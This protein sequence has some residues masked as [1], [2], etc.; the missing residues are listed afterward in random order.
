MKIRPLTPAKLHS[1]NTILNQLAQHFGDMATALG[2]FIQEEHAIVGQRHFAWHR[3]VAPADQPD[4]RD[5]VM[6]GATRAGRH[7]R[8]AVA[9]E[10]GDAVDACG[11]KGFGQGHRRQDGGE[12][13]CQHRLA[14]PRGAQEEVMLRMPASPFNGLPDLR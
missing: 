9:G 12:S 5:G 7:Q 10:A 6:G 8:G 11:L 4:I 2:E 14:S 1:C 13:P 3:H